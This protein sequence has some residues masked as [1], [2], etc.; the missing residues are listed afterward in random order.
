MQDVSLGLS[1]YLHYFLALSKHF[2]PK[3][4]YIKFSLQFL[5]GHM[6]PIFRSVVLVPITVSYVAV[7]QIVPD[8]PVPV[9]NR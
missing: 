1:F 7:I 5:A 2:L 8:L 4:N 6:E 3:E 9:V